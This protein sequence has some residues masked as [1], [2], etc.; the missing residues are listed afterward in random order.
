VICWTLCLTRK[1]WSS[2]SV[3]PP[4]NLWSRRRRR[5]LSGSWAASWCWTARPWATLYPA[6]PGSYTNLTAI[7]S[8]CQVRDIH[9][10][11]SIATY[12]M[13]SKSALCYMSAPYSYQHH[14]P[15][16]LHTPSQL[17][18]PC[19]PHTTCQLHNPCQLHLSIALVAPTQTTSGMV[20]LF[21]ERDV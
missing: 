13:Y 9:H 15:C 16:Q 12:S 17:H 8:S 5:A 21:D 4:Q 10:V 7:P 19:Q 18:T 20:Q 3:M 14:T 2:T 1:C 6:S 11:S